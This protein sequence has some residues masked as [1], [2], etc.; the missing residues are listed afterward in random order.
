[1]KK[2]GSE[3]GLYANESNTY[4]KELIHTNNNLD[5]AIGLIAKQAI[6]V[7]NLSKLIVF[8]AKAPT[9]CNYALKQQRLE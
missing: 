8:Q 3:D 6:W 4:M 2:W 9:T 1:M 7:E 5:D